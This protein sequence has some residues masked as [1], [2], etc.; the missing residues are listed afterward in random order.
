MKNYSEILR[1]SYSIVT[2]MAMTLLLWSCGGGQSSSNK[3][4]LE[5]AKQQTVQNINR[6]KNDIE[7]RISYVD[8]EI[9]T[10]S[11]EIKENLQTARAQLSEQKDL[12]NAELTNVQEASIETWNDVVAEASSAISQARSNTLEV[13]KK[14]R[15]LLDDME[16]E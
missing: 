2:I 13:S 6:I 16:D 12:L 14:V 15:N 8:S 9:E 1:K 4:Q 7:E 5:E 11:G 10:A 3:K